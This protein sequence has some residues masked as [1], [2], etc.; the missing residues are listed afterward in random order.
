VIGPVLSVETEVIE[1]ATDRKVLGLLGYE[2]LASFALR[3]DYRADT[4]ALIPMPHDGIAAAPPRRMTAADLAS[5]GAA[6]A[7]AHSASRDALREERR[8][9]NLR[10]ELV[11]RLEGRELVF[12]LEG[13]GAEE[14]FELAEG[15][16]HGVL[17]GIGDAAQSVGGV[18]GVARVG[19]GACGGFV[20][21]IRFVS[22]A[23][24][25]GRARLEARALGDQASREGAL[26]SALRRERGHDFFVTLPTSRGLYAQRARERACDGLGRVGGRVEIGRPRGEETP[27]ANSRSAR[28]VACGLSRP[29]GEVFA[30]LRGRSDERTRRVVYHERFDVVIRAIVLEPEERGQRDAIGR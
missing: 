29:H 23:V 25:C 5:S 19:C 1:Q 16:S 8:E 6:L 21:R 17:R 13:R 26:H 20:G 4:L 12:C 28:A 3:I 2:P 27:D 24:R 11:D 18:G 15:A 30:L 7:M 10:S 22:V 9:W 14:R